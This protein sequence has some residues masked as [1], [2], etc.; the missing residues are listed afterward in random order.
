MEVRPR[1]PVRVGKS[2]GVQNQKFY[3]SKY[4]LK[5]LFK[6]FKVFVIYFVASR[7]DW[8]AAPPSCLGSG[9]QARGKTPRRAQ[10][11]FP[12]Q[13]CTFKNPPTARS[14]CDPTARPWACRPFSAPHTPLIDSHNPYTPL[15][16]SP[17]CVGAGEWAHPTPRLP[18]HG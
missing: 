17:G 1:P 7:V 2:T 4:V 3:L 12:R 9:D 10:T 6:L 5:I 13:G 11:P 18:I 14:Y 16:V 15:R 8:R